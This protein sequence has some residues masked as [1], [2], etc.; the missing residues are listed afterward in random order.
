MIKLLINHN[1]RMQ[2]IIPSREA[3]ARF[4][5][6]AICWSSFV[7]ETKNEKKKSRQIDT[8]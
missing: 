5:A 1:I 8:L 2:I 4:A 7:V 6:F 3:I